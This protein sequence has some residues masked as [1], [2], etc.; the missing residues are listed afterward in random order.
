[1]KKSFGIYKTTLERAIEYR[2]NIENAIQEIMKKDIKNIYLIGCGGSLGVMFP[3]KYIL[4]INCSLPGYVYNA[5]EFLSLDPKNLDKKSLV[6]LSSYTGETK[7]TLDSAKYVK[8][9]GASTIGF[10]GEENSSLGKNVDYVF[11]NN[12]KEGVTD[13]K[14]IMLYQVIFNIIKRT[15]NYDRYDE[16]MDT[17]S[18]LPE[19]LVKIKEKVEEQAIEFAKNNK[20]EKFFMTLGSGPCWGEAYMFATCILE[21]MQWIKTQ[22]VHAGEYFHG[23]FEIVREDT[24]LIIFKGEDRTRPLIDRAEKFSRKYSKK[25]TLIDTKDFELPGVPDDFRGYL[26]PLVLLAVMDVYAKKLAEQR[27]HPL[28]IRKYMGKVEY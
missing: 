20:D 10:T 18:S 21:E 13:S 25:I 3:C 26:S 6:I 12:A 27:N 28:E 1:M 7:E 22:P 11:A 19:N 23:A 9:I 4:D 2:K 17:L 16:I 14:L 5:S 24:N 15:D 8:K